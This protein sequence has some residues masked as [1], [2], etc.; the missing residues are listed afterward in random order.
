MW[1]GILHDKGKVICKRL[2]LWLSGVVGV[3]V[4]IPLWSRSYLENIERMTFKISGSTGSTSEALDVVTFDPNSSYYEASWVK[5]SLRASYASVRENVKCCGCGCYCFLTVLRMVLRLWVHRRSFNG[6]VNCN[7]NC[8]LVSSI[9]TTTVQLY[10]PCDND[11]SVAPSITTT[12]IQWS[13]PS[14]Q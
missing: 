13:R 7:A 8:S 5:L 1:W 2:W 4:I 6:I 14:Q 9:T 11:C 3:R 12:T 10:R